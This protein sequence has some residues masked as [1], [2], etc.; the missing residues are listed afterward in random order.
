MYPFNP[1][2]DRL[3]RCQMAKRQ[4][5]FPKTPKMAQIGLRTWLKSDRSTWY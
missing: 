1:L 2:D 5:M 3:F 4:V